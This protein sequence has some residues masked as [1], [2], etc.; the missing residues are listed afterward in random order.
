MSEERPRGSR[1]FLKLA[2]LFL[3]GL[4]LS[5]ALF[6]MN[7]RRS[8]LA[9]LYHLGPEK[10]RLWTVECSEKGANFDIELLMLG[11]EDREFSVR[12]RAILAMDRNG[13]QSTPAISLLIHLIAKHEDYRTR[14]LAVHA[15]GKMDEQYF[16]IAAALLYA[17][18]DKNINVVIA[19][20]MSAERLKDKLDPEKYQ[21]IEA[22]VTSRIVVESSGVKRLRIQEDQGA[23]PA[24]SRR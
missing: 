12:Q 18:Q 16:D 10:V 13:S 20:S 11:A 8:A 6:G 14:G 2:L 21:N 15:L 19:A 23:S 17:T 3:L 4:G 24:S 9:A 22:L 5:W 7:I 1:R